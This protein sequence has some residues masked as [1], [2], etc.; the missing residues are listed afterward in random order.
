EPSPELSSLL[1]ELHTSKTL[2]KPREPSGLLRLQSLGQG[3]SE[4]PPV[5]A[6][7]TRPAAAPV[8]P[9]AADDLD[10]LLRYGQPQAPRLPPSFI[11]NPPPPPSSE[12]PPEHSL[13]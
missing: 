10:T 6:E 8:A 7:P 9:A 4:A 5:S 11:S 12:L 1:G 3:P 13:P 2:E